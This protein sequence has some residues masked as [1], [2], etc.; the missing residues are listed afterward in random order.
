[1]RPWKFKTRRFWYERGGVVNAPRWWVKLGPLVFEIR[2]DR[3]VVGFVASRWYIGVLVGPFTVT[4]GKRE[5]VEKER[6]EF[7]GTTTHSVTFTTS[8]QASA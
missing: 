3:W 1:M 2:L 5:W 8:D 7:G 4:V 6:W